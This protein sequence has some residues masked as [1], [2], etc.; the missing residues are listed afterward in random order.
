MKRLDVAA[1]KRG[2]ASSREKAKRL[3]A[4]GKIT[5]NGAVVTKP[6]FAVSDSDELAALESEI[7]FQAAGSAAVDDGIK[8][9]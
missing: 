6:A 5:V 4:D 7:I 8:I 2:L 9:R 3:I 1:A